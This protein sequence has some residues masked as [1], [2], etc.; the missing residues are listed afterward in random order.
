MRALIGV[1][2][3]IIGVLIAIAGVLYLTQPAHSLPTFLPGYV[4][5]ATGKHTKRGIAALAVGVVVGI[6][7]VVVMLAGR[8]RGYRW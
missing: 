7:A 1:V 5:H 8:R 2:L 4:A 6:V 3:L